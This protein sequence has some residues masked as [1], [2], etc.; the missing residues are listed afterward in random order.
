VNLVRDVLDT[1]VIDRHGREL[2]RADSIVLDVRPGAAPRIDRIEIGA[3]VLFSRVSPFL[4]RLVA[5][6]MFALFERREPLR[7]PFGDIVDIAPHHI[8][9]G[10][11]AGETTA[12][13]VESR[14][15]TWLRR[16]PGGS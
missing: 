14:F 16:I 8:K 10:L 9:T 15:R 3:G 5:G 13:D 12:N 6:A 11:V 7:I 1:L 4:G 2:G